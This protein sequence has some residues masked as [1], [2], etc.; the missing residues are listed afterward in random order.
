M[1]KEKKK[2]YIVILAVLIIYVVLMLLFVGK[3]ALVKNKDATTI[4]VGDYTV[5][6]YSD[7]N[8]L[9]ITNSTTL[10]DISWLDYDVYLDNKELGKYYLW[11]DDNKWY[12][13]DQNKKAINKEG[14]L[15]AFRSNYDIKVKNFDTKEIRNYYHVNKVLEENDLSTSSKY[16]VANEVSLDIDSDGQEETLYFVSNAFPLDFSPSKTFTFVF[17]VKNSKIYQI[18]NDVAPY[19]L[20]NGCKPYLSAVMDIDQDSTYE[21][22]VSCGRYSVSKP[23]DMLY[24]FTEE[25]FEILISNQ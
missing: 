2:R 22:V 5:W 25:E 19:K 21:I 23:V 9:N 12:I 20:N 13:F 6:N 16:T 24:K 3:D 18:Y 15:L 4:I 17:M 7:N 14:S 8:W 11:Y 10:D 1:K